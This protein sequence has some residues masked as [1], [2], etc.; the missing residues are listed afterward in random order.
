MDGQVPMINIQRFWMP[1][2]LALLGCLCTSVPASG[3]DAGA[4]E[5]SRE[6]HRAE[7][8]WRSGG[9][10]L[11]AKAR[12]DRVLK[13]EP[14]SVAGRKLRAHVLL[15]M[16][17]P[18]EA[19]L[20][21]RRA[22]ALASSQDPEALLLV[23]ESARLS[24]RRD[25]ALAALDAVSGQALTDAALHVRMAWNAAEMGLLDRAE[26]F[27]RIALQQ[28]TNLPSAYLQLARVFMQQGETA[29]AASVVVRGI[30]LGALDLRTLQ[31]DEVLKPLVDHPDVQAALK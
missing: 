28:D 11:E 20:D 27:A 19:L 8:A 12:V 13:M 1:C 17:R 23:C 14:S 22:V 18:A 2:V 26:A 24:G 21:A 4:S 31:A 25:E 3:Q 6:L 29:A 5:V 30:T 10:L 15:G 16:G 7:L 9:S